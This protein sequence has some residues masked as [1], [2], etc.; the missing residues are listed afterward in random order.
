M[1]VEGDSKR[2]IVLNKK[3]EA[4]IKPIMVLVIRE[5]KHLKFIKSN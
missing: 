1:K 3:S 5:F 4:Q 2:L